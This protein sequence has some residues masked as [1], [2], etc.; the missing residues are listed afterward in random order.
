MTEAIWE[1]KDGTKIPISRL[2]DLNLLNTEHILKRK[3]RQL[4][5]VC[6]PDF[7]GEMAQ[8]IADD[9][10]NSM[11]EADIEDVFPSYADICAEIQKRGL[12]TFEQ[13]AAQQS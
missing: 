9:Q 1:T 5:D 6:P 2:S 11:Q 3:F 4:Q 7:Q 10:W 8:M 12:V 13:F